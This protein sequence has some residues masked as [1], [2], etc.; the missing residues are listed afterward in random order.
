MSKTKEFFLYFI[1]NSLA[2]YFS[3]LFFPHSFALGTDRISFWLAVFISGA[4]WTLI[5][6]RLNLT[7]VSSKN[8]GQFASRW[9]FNF[10]AIWLTARVAPY[11]GFG[12]IKFTWLIPLSFVANIIQASISKEK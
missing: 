7:I 5:A 6:R 4:I 1:H 12:V 8:K 11:S 10:A 2:V 3:H 9:L